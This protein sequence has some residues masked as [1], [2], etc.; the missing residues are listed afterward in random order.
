MVLIVVA[1]LL[2]SLA[3]LC[4]AAWTMI[5]VR[6]LSQVELKNRVLMS[7]A[8]ANQANLELSHIYAE[9]DT[10][11]LREIPSYE[12]QFRILKV[13]SSEFAQELSALFDTVPLNSSSDSLGGLE[14]EARRMAER[15]IHLREQA[16]VMRDEAKRELYKS[17]PV[18][19]Q[20]RQRA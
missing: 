11:R 6:N 3:A 16:R 19:F 13:Q 20:P 1:S 7:F 18:N 5:A 17:Y 10:L 2:L 12:E 8:R 9:L 15:S 4:V 14:S